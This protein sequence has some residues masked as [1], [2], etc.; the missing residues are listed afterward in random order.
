M[1]SVLG[2]IWVNR[3]SFPSDVGKEIKGKN[4][5]LTCCY[6]YYWLLLFYWSTASLTRVATESLYLFSWWKTEINSSTCKINECVIG[7]VSSWQQSPQNISR[8]FPLDSDETIWNPR[9]FHFV[10]FNSLKFKWTCSILLNMEQWNFMSSSSVSLSWTTLASMFLDSPQT[11]N[12]S[13]I[14][15]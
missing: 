9:L 12:L 13:N 8:L 10:H 7:V 4:M 15:G 11:S 14:S 1:K 6:C 2:T 5:I 3:N